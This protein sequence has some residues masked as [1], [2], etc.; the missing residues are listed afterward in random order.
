MP[1]LAAP[2]LTNNNRRKVMTR[3]TYDYLLLLGWVVLVA[4]MT[5]GLAT[6]AFRVPS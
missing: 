6:I 5:D 3:Q 1:N 2:T 4:A